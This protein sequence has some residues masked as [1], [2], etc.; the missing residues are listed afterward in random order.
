MGFL[1]RFLGGNIIPYII[2]AVIA[3]GGFTWWYQ[4]KTT[5]VH[6]A[7]M[8][9]LFR[10]FKNVT[11]QAQKEENTRAEKLGAGNIEGDKIMRKIQDKIKQEYSQ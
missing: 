3:G 9:S 8:G 7:A 4:S 6:N 11:G 1:L 5:K 10:H 2:A